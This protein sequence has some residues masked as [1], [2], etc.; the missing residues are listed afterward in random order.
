MS[1]N[2]KKIFKSFQ[3]YFF[4]SMLIIAISIVGIFCFYW[5]SN[6]IDV[7]YL[8]AINEGTIIIDNLKKE[9]SVEEIYRL[10]ENDGVK[11][12]V[13]QFDQ[14]EQKI[15]IINSVDNNDIL[16][17]NEEDKQFNEQTKIIKNSI[18]KLTTY[19][20][21]NSLMKVFDS[22]VDKLEQIGSEIKWETVNRLALRLQIKLSTK[23]GYT[24]S[25]ALNDYVE[26]I[27]QTLA[28]IRGV[29]DKSVLDQVSK[30]KILNH[31]DS[32]QIEITIL[33]RYKNELKEFEN[34][35]EKYRQTYDKWM[36]G[37]II[38]TSNAKL[39]MIQSNRLF[40]VLIWFLVIMIVAMFGGAII[41]SIKEKK[42]TLS[43]IEEETLEI[44][45]KGVVALNPE[46]DKIFSADF[47]QEVKRANYYVQKRMSF[48]S[49]F[50]NALP[51][52]AMLLN[53]GL[54]VIWANPMFCDVFNI[55][56][57]EFEK[58]LLS[59]DYLKRFINLG[60]AEDPVS[61]TIKRNESKINIYQVKILKNQNVTYIPYE[62]YVSL[63]KHNDQKRVMVFF[64]PLTS[65]EEII[66]GQG[67]QLISPIL[68]MLSVLITDKYDTNVQSDMLKDF[69]N[70]GIEEVYEKFNSLHESISLQRF[71]ML[72]EISRLESRLSDNFK[73][74]TDIER[75]NAEYKNDQTELFKNLEKVKQNII[76]H[77]DINSSKVDSQTNTLLTYKNLSKYM[78]RVGEL[79][80][81]LNEKIIDGQKGIVLIIK[82]KKEFKSYKDYTSQML[83]K[84]TQML[85]LENINIGENNTCK[86]LYNKIKLL[87]EEFRNFEKNTNSFDVQCSKAQILMDFDSLNVDVLSDFSKKMNDFERKIEN[88]WEENNNLIENNKKIEESVI[89]SLNTLSLNYKMQLNYLKKV[90]S[91]IR[92]FLQSDLDGNG[93]ILQNNIDCHHANLK[94]REEKSVE[95]SD[96]LR[97][98]EKTSALEIIN[99]KSS[100]NEMDNIKDINKTI[101]NGQMM[102]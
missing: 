50:Q 53:S 6:L 25:S 21:I 95:I 73:L 5:K 40:I 88:N 91:I 39:E 41:L 93:T 87:E 69:I 36:A 35:Y 8:T 15:K 77:I 99:K 24:T 9:K 22:K 81:K 63:V 96:K 20:E 34:N 18:S 64:Y 46:V 48:S 62:M 67:R 10:I 4:L 70:S 13:Q 57:F 65:M 37:K 14:F 74:I 79:A 102:M 82:F 33:D 80:K 38:T 68:K 94:L 32:V 98:I 72:N 1:K 28:L 52:P 97:G 58:E 71:N 19:P 47:T 60:E 75:E 27:K 30:Q 66:K 83:Q 56:D 43:I 85:E 12:A 45:K 44:I 17:I 59:W 11:L 16:N 23:K 61:L 49:I 92:E 31:L 101:N 76:Q 3:I 100:I 78:N 26:K 42:N 55:K 2:M 51:F 54:K 90:S 86:L 7:N 89:E 29:V 84:I